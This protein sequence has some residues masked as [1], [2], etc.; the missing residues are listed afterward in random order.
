MMVADCPHRGRTLVG[1]SDLLAL[2]N[3]ASGVIVMHW[4]CACGGTHL[5][6]TGGVAAAD[7]VHAAAA[8]EAVR[9]VL[10]GE[11]AGAEVSLLFDD[12]DETPERRAC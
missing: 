6:A 7:P 5:T 4:T 10:D 9:R 3:V 11:P 2:V 12:E 8:V 1:Y